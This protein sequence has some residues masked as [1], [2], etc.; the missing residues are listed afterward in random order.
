MPSLIEEPLAPNK[1]GE[2]SLIATGILLPAIA[3][4]SSL[5]AH[6]VAP[7]MQAANIDTK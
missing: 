2:D 7:N 6:D 3:S 1:S 4:S 5:S